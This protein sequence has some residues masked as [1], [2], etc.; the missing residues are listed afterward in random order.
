MSD[1]GWKEAIIEVLNE[2][3][4]PLH[5]TDIA[6]RIVEL[7][8]RT[9]FGAT[10]AKAVCAAINA[11]H[12]AEGEVS[13]FVRVGRG[14]YALRSALASLDTMPTSSGGQTVAT[15]QEAE[16]DEMGLINA[17]GMYWKRDAV[18]WSTTPKILGQQQLGASPVDFS[19]QRGVYL[20]HD[21]RNVIYVGRTTDQP[22]GRRLF[23]HTMD[24]LNGRWDRFSWFGVYAVTQEGSL[25]PNG[26]ASF[27]L[28]NLIV[29]MEALLIEGLEPPQNRKRGD[30]FRAI[31]FLQV[32]DPE[33]HK[34]KILSLMDELKTKL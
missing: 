7:G 23:Q 3:T 11:S 14:M 26:P 24:R 15:D 8:L 5:Y 1:L 18:L 13:P 10:P 6:D 30:D 22:L 25:Q 31:E 19:E 4:E 28:N 20:L 33:I 21:S 16:P 29:T 12:N 17:F 27:S 32:V 9:E 34:S 2:A